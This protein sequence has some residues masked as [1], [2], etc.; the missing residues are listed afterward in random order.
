MKYMAGLKFLTS[1]FNSSVPRSWISLITFLLSALMTFSVPGSLE[2][3]GK[4]T[5]IDSVAGF[6]ETSKIK[7]FLSLFFT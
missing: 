4:Q 1:K 6:G 5:V 7:L 2:L 3:K